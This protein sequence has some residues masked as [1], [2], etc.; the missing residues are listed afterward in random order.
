[1]WIRRVTWVLQTL[2]LFLGLTIYIIL[3]VVEGNKDYATS[4]VWGLCN[5]VFTVIDYHFNQV[6]IYKYHHYDVPDEVKKE[7]KLFTSSSASEVSEQ[8]EA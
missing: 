2:G 5:A 1:M 7:R 4:L 6:V 8:V 3:D